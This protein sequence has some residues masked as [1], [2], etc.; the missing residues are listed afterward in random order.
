MW[1][2]SIRT[3]LVGCHICFQVWRWRSQ[4]RRK[5]SVFKWLQSLPCR[6]SLFKHC[7]RVTYICPEKLAGLKM[8]NSR[9]QTVPCKRSAPTVR[10]N[11]QNQ[12]IGSSMFRFYISPF[13]CFIL[14]ARVYR[15]SCTKG[16]SSLWH[17][18]MLWWSRTYY[19]SL[20]HTRTNLLL[21]LLLTLL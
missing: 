6:Q 17:K 21:L 9:F 19:N 11:G 12:A 2:V 18:L 16:I 15:A 5:R 7:W 10:M 1:M 14:Y 13:Y 3:S 20:C 4:S 8:P